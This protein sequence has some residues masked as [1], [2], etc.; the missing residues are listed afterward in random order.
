MLLNVAMSTF[1]KKILLSIFGLVV[2]IPLIKLSILW[3]S[4]YFVLRH[5]FKFEFKFIIGFF[6][7]AIFSIFQDLAILSQ[8]EYPSL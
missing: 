4:Q 6:L 8:D 1:Y 7:F 3:R 5:G 2:W